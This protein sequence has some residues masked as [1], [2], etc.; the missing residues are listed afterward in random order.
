MYYYG[1]ISA[2]IVVHNLSALKNVYRKKKKIIFRQRKG[3]GRVRMIM[4]RIKQVVL[5]GKK[6]QRGGKKKMLDFYATGRPLAMS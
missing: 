3:D 2:V 6:R 1:I 4:L 5:F